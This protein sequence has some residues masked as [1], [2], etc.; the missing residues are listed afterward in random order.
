FVQFGEL[1]E[2]DRYLERNAIYNN[3]A[4]NYLMSYYI[5]NN[6]KNLK[7]IQS[8]YGLNVGEKPRLEIYG[9][10]ELKNNSKISANIEYILNDKKDRYVDSEVIYLPKRGLKYE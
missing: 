9:D 3:Q 10:G 4:P 5:K 2:L 7:Q 1:K 6:D 8:A